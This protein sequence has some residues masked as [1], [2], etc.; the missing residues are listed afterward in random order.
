LN[1]I[2]Y[3]LSLLYGWNLAPPTPFSGIQYKTGGD[4]Q[5]AQQ[6][7][8][9]RIEHQY[10]DATIR[11]ALKTATAG[12]TASGS[13]TISPSETG[14]TASDLLTFSSGSTDW[15]YAGST[16]DLS[17]LSLTAGDRYII[18]SKVVSS[19]TWAAAWAKLDYMFESAGSTGWTTPP[20]I[21]GTIEASALNIWRDDLDWLKDRIAL[22]IH[23]FGI[24]D[25]QTGGASEDADRLVHGHVKHTGNTFRYK[26]L[27]RLIPKQIVP[28]DPSKPSYETVLGVS[29][30][31]VVINGST[32]ACTTGARSDSGWEMT[33]GSLDLSGKGLT[34]GNMYEVY[35]SA[36]NRDADS[37]QVECRLAY[38]YQDDSISPSGW[39]APKS[40]SHGDTPV[41]ASGQQISDNLTSLHDERRDMIWPTR[42]NYFKGGAVTPSEQRYVGVAIIHRAPWLNYVGSGEL[43]LAGKDDRLSFGP[44]S[45]TAPTTTWGTVNL[46]EWAALQLGQVYYVL[47]EDLIVAFESWKSS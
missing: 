25:A 40:W 14:A 34:A 24:F 20:T 33:T 35:L 29:E 45:D 30:A 23:S 27:Q 42:D 3:D 4:H 18:R 38:A 22:P 26:F 10:N 37:S 7:G 8:R 21:S 15:E 44:A 9:W 12:C 36:K 28:N 13:V 17:S 46:D 39:G 6:F 47:G 2:N 1:L 11:F 31:W 41:A 5:V 16:L 43:K 19:T 32:A